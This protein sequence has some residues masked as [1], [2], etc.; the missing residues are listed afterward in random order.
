VICAGCGDGLLHVE[1]VGWR[2][3]DGTLVRRQCNECGRRVSD[4]GK[5]RMCPICGCV[6]LGASDVAVPLAP[7]HIAYYEEAKRRAR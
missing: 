6:A 7:E 5:S 1:Y 4:Q 3:K 2:H